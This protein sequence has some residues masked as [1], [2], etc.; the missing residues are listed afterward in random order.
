MLPLHGVHLRIYGAEQ[1]EIV[2]LPIPSHHA[3]ANAHGQLLLHT[4]LLHLGYDL[5]LAAGSTTVDQRFV[6][7]RDTYKAPSGLICPM[8]KILLM[9]VLA[10]V[11]A[12]SFSALKQASSGIKKR[13]FF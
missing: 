7:W 9:P 4:R 5:D 13:H 8:T 1:R 6:Q 12:G 3:E 10:F 11:N 2:T